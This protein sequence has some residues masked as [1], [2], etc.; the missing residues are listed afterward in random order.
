VA[1]QSGTAAPSLS[2]SLH[3][4]K[5]GL[6]GGCPHGWMIGS[7]GRDASAT[8]SESAVQQVR[9]PSTR[10]SRRVAKHTGRVRGHAD[11]CARDLDVL[12]GSVAGLGFWLTVMGL[13]GCD[14][15]LSLH[16]ARPPGCARVQRVPPTSRR[17]PALLVAEVCRAVRPAPAF[18]FGQAGKATGDCRM[19]H[20]GQ[21]STMA[22]LTRGG[23]SSAVASSAGGRGWG[24][25]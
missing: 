17:Q 13:R 9:W 8:I 6:T 11:E 20:R 14:V 22:V 2:L 15:Y 24:W 16:R 10:T 18:S 1:N 4:S 23:S 25:G 7:A 5:V 3:R 12:A 21:A 19:F